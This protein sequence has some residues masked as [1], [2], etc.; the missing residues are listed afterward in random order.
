MK[1]L[2]LLSGGIDS[3]VCL[4][5]L[6]GQ[7]RAAI[8]F[9]YGQRHRIELLYAE[10]LAHSE[11]VSLY[12]WTLPNLRLVNDI[13][14]AGRNAIMLSVAAAFAQSYGY[15]RIIIG[16]NADDAERFP[17]CRPQFIGRIGAAFIE[18]YGVDLRAP[19]LYLSKR[20][21]IQ[22]AH[23]LRLDLNFTRIRYAPIE[24]DGGSSP[25]GECYACQV[26]E[27]AS[28]EHL[29]DRVPVCRI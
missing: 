9:D 2:V 28:N 26:R 16:C 29:R 27:L 15:D 1:S 25:C 23:A 18:A 13:V 14:F 20:A 19:L 21:V 24:G 3:A 11:D 7:E 17:D 5:L 12:W 4:A 22:E 6:R 8:A 10:K